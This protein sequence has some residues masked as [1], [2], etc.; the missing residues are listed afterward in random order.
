MKIIPKNP[1]LSGLL[2]G[3]IRVLAT[4]G[5]GFGLLYLLNFL[6][7]DLGLVG[8]VVG[9]ISVIFLHF[10]LPFAVGY[11]YS[12][13]YNKILSNMSRLKISFM[14]MLSSAVFIV[15]GSRC[16]S[17]AG[18]W[19]SA[20]VL[21]IPIIDYVFLGLGSNSYITGL[22]HEHHQRSDQESI[23]TAL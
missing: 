13:K 21:L 5:I 4:G 8:T 7:G 12:K 18:N 14:D 16:F 1:W 9:S 22:T 11:Y 20:E 3:A 15:I 19:P 6:G 23:N 2:L 10:F 17:G